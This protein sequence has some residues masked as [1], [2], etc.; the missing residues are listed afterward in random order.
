M[1]RRPDVWSVLVPNTSGGSSH[2]VLD[3]FTL[4]STQDTRVHFAQRSIR[5]HASR[6][7]SY[8]STEA[9]HIRWNTRVYATR[10][11]C[12]PVPASCVRV[13][14]RACVCVC[15][16]ASVCRAV[17]RS[18][19]TQL[20]ARACVYT[21]CHLASE[22]SPLGIRHPWFLKPWAVVPY[23]LPAPLCISLHPT[24]NLPPW[25]QRP[26]FPSR[27][28]ST[29]TAF[30]LTLPPSPSPTLSLSLSCAHDP[31]HPLY[32]CFSFPRA[33]PACCQ[34]C[35]S[36]SPA[37]QPPAD[38]PRRRPALSPRSSAAP[39]FSLTALPLLTVALP[40]SCVLLRSPARSAPSQKTQVQCR[41]NGG[42]LP[43]PSFTL[44]PSY[45]VPPSPPPLSPPGRATLRAPLPSSPPSPS[46]YVPVSVPLPS[47]VS[48]CSLYLRPIVP[49]L[50]VGSL[51]SSLSLSLLSL[52]L[53]LSPSI[54]VTLTL[55][56][57]FPL[58]ACLSACWI[59]TLNLRQPMTLGLVSARDN[60]PGRLLQTLSRIRAFEGAS[61]HWQFESVLH[62]TR[63][64]NH[65]GHVEINTPW[66]YF[67]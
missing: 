21:V 16:C 58:A 13:S 9:R 39:W 19:V 64:S 38:P 18:C 49:F 8:T 63:N 10:A 35:L 36:L 4:L 54:R 52:F 3:P 60:L 56:R 31:F 20:G 50:F 11:T 30:T 14:Q 24:H 59:V 66:M 41:R 12:L 57:S 1:Q 27:P 23:P 48:S 15:T 61:R 2:H 29:F 5:T 6:Y 65:F 51:S 28:P 22:Q 33:A 17:F 45:V 46:S 40:S 55:W 7:A 37:P 44:F 53:S 62:T 42:F 47:Q 43:S 26:S 32:L 25:A 34:F 67:L